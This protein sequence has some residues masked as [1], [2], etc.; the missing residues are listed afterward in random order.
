MT[1]NL[2]NINLALTLHIERSCP[3]LLFFWINYQ[4]ATLEELNWTGKG[5]ISCLY[6]DVCCRHR[7]QG[8]VLYLVQYLTCVIA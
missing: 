3:L 8:R 7:S 4:I 2:S 6:A 5:I 1:S